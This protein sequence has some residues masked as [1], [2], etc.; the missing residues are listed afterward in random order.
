MNRLVNIG[1]IAILALLICSCDRDKQSATKSFL[2]IGEFTINK[3]SSNLTL[4][5]DGAGRTLALVPREAPAPEGYEPQM[6]VR[7][8]VKRVVAYGS[9]DVATLRVFGRLR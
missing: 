9:F 7:T 4:V 5:R 8:P 6:I 3:V 2:Q 1:L